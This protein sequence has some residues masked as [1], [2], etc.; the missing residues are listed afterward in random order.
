MRKK[1]CAYVGGMGYLELITSM[2]GFMHL[3]N[4]SILFRVSVA[5]NFFLQMYLTEISGD[6]DL[7]Q[8]EPHRPSGFCG[9]YISVIMRFIILKQK[10]KNAYSTK[11]N[12]NLL[13]FQSDGLNVEIHS[14]R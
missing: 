2:Y 4:R 8:P 13:N 6:F 5:R 10:T 7:K 11:L 14:N 1:N 9:P 12:C 3:I